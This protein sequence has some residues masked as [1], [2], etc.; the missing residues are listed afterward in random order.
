M[1][2]VQTPVVGSAHPTPVSIS[3]VAPARQCDYEYDFDFD[4][5]YDYDFDFD[6]DF[7]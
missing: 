4:Y 7:D 1:K 6:F 2:N 5:D 3:W